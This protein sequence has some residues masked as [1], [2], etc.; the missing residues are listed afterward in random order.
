MAGGERTGFDEY[1]ETRCEMEKIGF[2]R[3]RVR[4]RSGMEDE[5]VCL[6]LCSHQT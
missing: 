2:P 6:L 4:R 1:V 5:C 3:Q